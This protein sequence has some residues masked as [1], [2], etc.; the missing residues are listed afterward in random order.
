MGLR[1]SVSGISI[2]LVKKFLKGKRST[3]MVSLNCVWSAK[4]KYEVNRA[5]L[6]LGN[7]ARSIRERK[8]R[9]PL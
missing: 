7:L 4:E 2:I 8:K 6:F 5:Q 9:A 1:D 3:F